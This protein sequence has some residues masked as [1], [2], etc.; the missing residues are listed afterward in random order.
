MTEPDQKEQMQRL[1]DRIEAAKK[2]QDP[3]PRVD[4]HYSAANL[5][6]RMVI[7]L[8]A[9]LGIGFGIGYGLDVLF[10]TIPLFMLLFTLLGL[11]A[12]IKTM[13]RSAKEIE[14]EKLAEEAEKNERN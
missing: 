9:G 13:M 1:H 14:A 6:W 11:T 10:G 4:E 3:K 7:E 2:A 12:G 8:V 5:A